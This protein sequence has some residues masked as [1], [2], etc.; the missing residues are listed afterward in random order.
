MAL[1]TFNPDPPPSPGTDLK[2]K[3]KLLKADFGDGYT[4]AAADGINWIKGTLTL[5]WDNLTLSQAVAIDNFFIAQGGYIPFY[6]TPSD[7]TA[8]MKWTCED[9][10]VKRGQGG[11]RTIT[12]TLTQNFSTL[13]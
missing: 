13:T 2:R 12:A 1:N 4:Q 10:S 8:P 7:D 5:T 11:I 9:W 6:Y 3:P